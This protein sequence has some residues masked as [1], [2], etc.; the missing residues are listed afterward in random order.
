MELLYLI[1]VSLTECF[2][3]EDYQSLCFFSGSWFSFSFLLFSSLFGWQLFW[4]ALN[5]FLWLLEFL[6]CRIGRISDLGESASGGKE[7]GS[8]T[9]SDI[10][11]YL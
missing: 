5:S 2:G 11:L 1:T 6:L 9:W 4:C 8:K 7:E 3:R 10:V